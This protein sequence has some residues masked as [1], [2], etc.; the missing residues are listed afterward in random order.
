MVGR[1]VS[2]LPHCPDLRTEAGDHLSSADGAYRRHCVRRS[3]WRKVAEREL[4]SRLAQP[5]SCGDAAMLARVM[6][7]AEGG[8]AAAGAGWR[9]LNRANWD[10]RVPI[11]LASRLYDLELVAQS[12]RTRVT[13]GHIR[14]HRESVPPAPERRIW[15]GFSE[16]LAAGSPRI[17][18]LK[19]R[20][21]GSPRR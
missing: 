11:H 5:R 7:P 4:G 9:A 18:A 1:A 14:G 19:C 8:D 2:A 10:D 12:R 15:A 20:C 17:S 6:A 3:N 21:C 16:Y 13:P